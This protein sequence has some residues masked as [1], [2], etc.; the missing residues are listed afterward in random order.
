MDRK[1]GGTL[2]THFLPID[3]SQITWQGT[4]KVYESTKP[5]IF[6]DFCAD[7]GS[8]LTWRSHGIPNQPDIYQITCGT[9]D[10][11]VLMGPN[12]KDFTFTFR[13]YW[14]CRAIQGVTDNL[15]GVGERWVEGDT[16]V[17]SDIAYQYVNRKTPSLATIRAANA[18]YT[19]SHIPVGVFVGGTSGIGQG[20]AEAF[21]RHTKGNARIVI[22][23]RNREAAEKIIAKF[24]KPSNSE[25][26]FEFLECD[27]SV[28]NNVHATTTELLKRHPKINFLV[29]TPGYFTT[30]G[31][32]P[33]VDGIDRKLAVHYY[34]RWKFAK[35]L[36][37]L[38][39]AAAQDGEDAKIFSEIANR[40]PKIT[41]MHAHPG[42]VRTNLGASAETCSVEECGEYLFNGLLNHT[43]GYWRIGSRGE[44]LGK[45]EYKAGADKI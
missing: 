23:G 18:A 38:L 16:L 41:A 44:D 45:R 20:I 30:A 4:P 8:T 32:T 15:G 22:V 33:T 1:A 13:Q 21:A 25:A 31:F 35:E 37:P 7:C 17:A 14:C 43:G 24:P 2:V 39:E 6:R 10:E 40:H 19:A 28:M 5:G 9:L 34:G 12:A 3:P 27:I 26:S 11:E 29:M 42:G 36:M